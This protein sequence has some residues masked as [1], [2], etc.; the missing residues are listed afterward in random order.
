MCARR[1]AIDFVSKYCGTGVMLW[2]RVAFMRALERV[3][4]TSSRT[5]KSKS[6]AADNIDEPVVYSTSKASQWKARQTFRP[7][8]R[9]QDMPSAQPI[10]VLISMGAFMLYFFVLREENDVD[11]MLY[12]P[13][14]ETIPGIDK[15][16][17][18]IARFG[19]K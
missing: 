18:G 5:C 1:K 14:N 9:V 15:T 10:S 8:Q 4:Y 7:P 17:W 3:R 11:E 19:K 2:Q 13:L 16:D 12:R 6:S